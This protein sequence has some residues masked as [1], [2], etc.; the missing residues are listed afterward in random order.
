LALKATKNVVECYINEQTMMVNSQAGFE[1]YYN[2]AFFSRDEY[3]TWCKELAEYQEFVKSSP[4]KANIA[5]FWDSSLPETTRGKNPK[6]QYADFYS[7][8]CTQTFC[9]DCR[10]EEY[11]AE[12]ARRDAQRS[13]EEQELRRRDITRREAEQ[14]RI[15]LATANA[16]RYRAFALQISDDWEQ[17]NVEVVLNELSAANYVPKRTL[18]LFGLG[19]SRGNVTAGYSVEGSNRTHE[20]DGNSAYGMPFRIRMENNLEDL[21]VH[22]RAIIAEEVSQTQDREPII[23]GQNAEG[24]MSIEPENPL[25]GAAIRIT[26]D[27]WQPFRPISP[28]D[29]WTVVENTTAAPRRQEV[30]FRVEPEMVE[31]TPD[32]P[33]ARPP[34]QSSG[35]IRFRPLSGIPAPISV[36]APRP[37]SRPE[38]AID[39]MFAREWRDIRNR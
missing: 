30:E 24:V 20:F 21:A 32:S 26:R 6:C 16:E 31:V 15:A 23:I 10:P 14:R 12:M 38:E 28:S 37:I 17:E 2:Y 5:H 19:S 7:G 25:R 18:H 34:E 27:G 39:E 11:A 8:K 22:V 29:G 36:S 3:D 13:A 4:Y 33:A 1:D 9:P 35:G